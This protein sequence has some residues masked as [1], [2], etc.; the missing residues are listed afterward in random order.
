MGLESQKRL[1]KVIVP[2]LR[3]QAHLLPVPH[4]LIAAKNDLRR[5]MWESI[6]MVSAEELGTHTESLLD[7]LKEGPLSSAI[8][9]ACVALFGGIQGEPD[10]LPLI[11]WLTGRGARPVFFGFDE[12]GLVP[13][14]V[15]NASS[16][17]RGPFGV[18]MPDESCQRLDFSDLDLVLV[19]GLAFD[20]HGGR[21]GR[22]RGYFDRLFGMPEVRAQRIG[23]CFQ[24]QVVA[25]VPVESHDARVQLIVTDQG[26]IRVDST[27]L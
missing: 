21:L 19:P 18:W 17:S 6:R 15:T 12:H 20:R 2:S 14:W 11:P 16:L 24:P 9:G 10:L 5:Q 25:E 8:N 7:H 27:A 3:T 1:C 26:V 13:R 4:D 23:V 22:G